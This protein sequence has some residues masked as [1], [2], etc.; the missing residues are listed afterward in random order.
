MTLTTTENTCYVKSFQNSFA[1]GLSLTTKIFHFY[2]NISIKLSAFWL[3][4]NP[5]K[6]R[7]YSLFV[8][9]FSVDNFEMPANENL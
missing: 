7:D 8:L 6:K 3:Q 1:T 9:V 4:S 2:M 5:K